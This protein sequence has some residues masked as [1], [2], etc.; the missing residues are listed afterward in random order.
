MTGAWFRFGWAAAV[1]FAG[2]AACEE[3]SKSD[4]ESSAASADAGAR[5]PAVDPNLAEAITEVAQQPGGP[6]LGGKGPPQTGVFEPGVADKQ[7]PLG[8]PPQLTL[9]SEGSA[10]KVALFTE[11]VRPGK[12][13]EAA[14]RVSVRTGPRAAMP[15]IDFLVVFDATQAKTE[16]DGKERGPSSV[17]A[18][19]TS[20]KPAAEQP[21]M[22]PE[23]VANEVAKL[24]GSQIEYQLNANGGAQG[25][26]A[27]PS[28]GMDGALG[29]VVEALGEVLATVHVPYP[30]KP[31]GQGAYWMVASREIYAGVDTLAYRMFKVEKLEGE[32]ATLSVNTKRYVA[33]GQLSFP[34]LPPHRVDEFQATGRGELSVRA[35]AGLDQVRLNEAMM[36]NL[37]PGSDPGR[38]ITAQFDVTTQFAF[39]SGG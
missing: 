15:T 18:R 28:K 12:K 26:R 9:G 38:R 2:L 5:T 27:M 39:A 17:V 33:A 1:C 16:D 36:T 23:G 11:L 29:R 30:D 22:L 3:K 14:V 20:A 35:G 34:G 19:V 7:L 13:R 32:N 24:K 25:I 8:S 6:E 4:A 10:P 31:V 21:G 37:A